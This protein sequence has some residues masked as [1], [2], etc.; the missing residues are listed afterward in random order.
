MKNLIWAKITKSLC[1][2]FLIFSLLVCAYPKSI[3]WA[4]EEPSTSPEE[5]APTHNYR[6]L[7]EIEYSGTFTF[8]Y[9]WGIW[10]SEKCAYVASQDSQNPAEGTVEGMPG[11]YGFDGFTNKISFTNFSLDSSVEIYARLDYHTE[12]WYENGELKEFPDIDPLKMTFYKDWT[13]DREAIAG[14]SDAYG[15]NGCIVNIPYLEPDDVDGTKIYPSTDIYFSLE[16][17]PYLENDEM[18]HSPSPSAIGFIK[19]T[20]GTSADSLKPKS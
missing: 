13:G 11:W 16:G 14:I 12:N 17:Q 2:V 1:A 9:D 18:F 8:T 7:L 19:I 15:Q 5:E 20:V 6:Y 3:V 4:A 10:D